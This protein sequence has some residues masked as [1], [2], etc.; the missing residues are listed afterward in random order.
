MLI[1]W[2][3]SFDMG[4]TD[5][6]GTGRYESGKPNY[7]KLEKNKYRPVLEIWMKE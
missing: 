7:E 3:G 1:I 4:V 5:R 6:E 2:P